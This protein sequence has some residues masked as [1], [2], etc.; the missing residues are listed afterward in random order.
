MTLNIVFLGVTIWGAVVLVRMAESE[1]AMMR[2]KV[3]NGDALQKQLANEADRT[4]V[5]KAFELE[6]NYQIAG[7]E[8]SNPPVLDMAL[9]KSKEDLEARKKVVSEFIRASKELQYFCDSATDAYGRELLKLDLTPEARDASLKKFIETVQGMNPT[10][11]ALRKADV[12]RGEAMLK[13]L[14]FLD[15]SWGKW[16]YSLKTHR[17]QFNV[18]KLL[19]DYNRC[20][21]ELK[22]ASKEVLRLQAESRRLNSRPPAVP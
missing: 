12:R 9:V 20:N 10:I 7:A 8:L 18:V 6:K 17:L 5:A 15:A 13:L 21:Q 3:G 2:A 19:D 4:F 14:T 1:A 16:E 22:D 11:K